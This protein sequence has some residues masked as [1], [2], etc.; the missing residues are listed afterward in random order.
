MV[1]VYCKGRGRRG[2]GGRRL[3]EGDSLIASRRGAEKASHRHA[4]SLQAALVL[5]ETLVEAILVDKLTVRWLSCRG[6]LETI[7]H[8]FSM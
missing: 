7:L 4:L 5:L 6:A 8:P 1:R 3:R 2:G